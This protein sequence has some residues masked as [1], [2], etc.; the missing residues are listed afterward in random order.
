MVTWYRLLDS[1]RTPL[2]VV[3]IAR[4]YLA[5]WTPEEIAR[6]PVAVR[7]KKLRDERDIEDLHGALVEEYR[8]TVATGLALDALQRLTTFMVRAT[9]RISEV[10]ESKATGEPSSARSKS[11]AS[12]REH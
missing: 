12:R 1:A 7:P 11:A 6:L 5:T 3:A 8:D 10:S 4:D 2:E 9:I